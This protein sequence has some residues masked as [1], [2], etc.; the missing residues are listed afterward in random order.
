MLPRVDLN[1][2]LQASQSEAL[3]ALYLNITDNAFSK[4]RAK[5][6]IEAKILADLARNLLQ[7]PGFSVAKQQGYLLNYAGLFT[8]REEFDVLRFSKNRVLNIELKRQFPEKS[9]IIDQLRRHKVILDQL[10]KKTIL[11]TYVYSVKT[12]F[13]LKNDQLI[14]ISYA[15]LATLIADDYLFDNELVKLTQDAPKADL[16]PPL[17]PNLEITFTPKSQ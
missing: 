13:L 3:L 15:Y 10:G 9:H 6:I 8:V 17:Q 2:L 14:E 11:C 5:T 1:A 7:L 16:Q 12:I 4:N